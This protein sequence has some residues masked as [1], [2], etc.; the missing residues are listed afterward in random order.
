MA[1]RLPLILSQ[2]SRRDANAAEAIENIVAAAMLLPKLDANLIGDLNSIE[3]GG[4]D[5]L[6]LQGHARDIILVS[7]LQLDQA[8]AAWQRLEQ[9]GHFVDCATSAAAIRA[10]LSAVTGV[11]RV[12][13][14][15]LTPSVRVATLLD[16][17]QE[18]V[19]AQS[20]NLVTIQ[21]GSAVQSKPANGGARPSGMAS[22][23]A[24]PIVAPSASPLRTPQTVTASSGSA[25]NGSPGMPAAT[26]QSDM[27]PVKTQS[28][29]PQSHED[30][31]DWSAIDQLV[32][33]LDALDL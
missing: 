18:L 13:Y 11:R 2:P 3:V 30:N 31:E 23:A 1:V 7:F 4:T 10:Q 21:F 12:F 22:T 20:L 8:R 29:V 33:D 26:M 17:C 24:L 6:C 5:H 19:A 32:D 28:Y 27:M 14:F 9:P 16:Q 15:Q 25:A